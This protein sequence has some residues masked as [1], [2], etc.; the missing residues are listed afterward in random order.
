MP[1][2]V[3]IPPQ[4]TAL[5]HALLHWKQEGPWCEE[6][7]KDTHEQRHTH[8]ESSTNQEISASRK[9]LFIKNIEV[10]KEEEGGGGMDGKFGA[11]RCQL[12][13]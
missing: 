5:G 7:A 6:T 1:P 12:L 3:L 9:W 11:R 10:A 8:A 4:I 2:G 13:H